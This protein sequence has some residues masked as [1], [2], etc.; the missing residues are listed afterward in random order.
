MSLDELDTMMQSAKIQSQY[1]RI[2]FTLPGV[3][4]GDMVMGKVKFIVKAIDEGGMQI[5]L[6]EFTPGMPGETSDTGNPGRLGGGQ[7]IPSPS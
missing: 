4:P 7:I 6:M 3:K 2:P 5:M 1:T